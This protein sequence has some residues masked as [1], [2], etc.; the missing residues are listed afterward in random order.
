MRMCAIRRLQ[1][2]SLAMVVGIGMLVAQ[3]IRIQRS[4]MALRAGQQQGSRRMTVSIATGTIYDG[5][6]QPLTNRETQRIAVVNPSPD[7][8]ASIYAAVQDKQKLEEQLQQ[9]NPFLCSINGETVAH[10]NVQLFDIRKNTVG[11]QPAQ[12]LIGYRQNGEGV[13]GLERAYDAWLQ[14]CDVTAQVWFDVDAVGTALPGRDTSAAIDGAIGGGIVTTLDGNIQQITETALAEGTELP[15]AAVVLDV[16]T[17]EIVAMAGQ[18]CYDPDNLAAY[19]DDTDAPFLNRALCAYSVGSVFKLVVA[20]T[21]LEQNIPPNYMYDCCGETMLYGQRFRCHNHSGHGLL[22]MSDALVVSCNPYF[23]SL[24]Q[25]LSISNMRQVA[26]KLGFGQSI[27][28]AD[29][30]ASAAGYL[31]SESE[32]AVKAE[33]ANLAFGQGKLL[34]TPLQVAAM[35]ACIANDGIYCTPRL[36]LGLTE[37]GETILPTTELQSHT[38]IS[39]STAM[40][41]QT[42]MG[43]VLSESEQTNGKP[44]YTTAGGKTSTA[45]TGRKDAD[46]KELCHAWMSGFFPLDAPEYAV[47]VF[48]ENGGS[49]NGTAAPI[50]RQIIDTMARQG[51]VTG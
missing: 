43:S 45:Q 10:P 5:N 51:Y 24:S 26:E 37:D 41:L 13:A 14:S 39:K 17:G 49:G 25:L 34:A 29:G 6:M 38:A 46:G 23:I 36:V 19:L 2:V 31:Q 22:N 12:H 18:P 7:A 32:L 9:G 27:P 42:M 50:F 15:A 3:L 28:L 33:K 16:Q 11:K 47:T 40:T 4:D 20:A 21:A 48:V 1:A 44:Q 30:I 35:T 8:I